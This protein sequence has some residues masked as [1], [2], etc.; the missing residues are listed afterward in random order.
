MQKK[1][2]PKPYPRHK[3]PVGDKPNFLQD[4]DTDAANTEEHEYEDIDDFLLP[5]PAENFKLPPTNLPR[6]ERVHNCMYC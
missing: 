5:T 4:I 3:K 2:K 1:T 6:L